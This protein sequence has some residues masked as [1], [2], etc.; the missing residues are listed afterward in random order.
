VYKVT[1]NIAPTLTTYSL[2]SWGPPTTT[3]ERPVRLATTRVSPIQ[4]ERPVHVPRVSRKVV[5]N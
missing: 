4:V 3:I 1:K 2:R 5:E